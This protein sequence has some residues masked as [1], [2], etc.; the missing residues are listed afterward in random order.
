MVSCG[1][2]IWSEVIFIPRGSSVLSRLALLVFPSSDRAG[3]T[4]D[5]LR[6]SSSKSR[7]INIIVIV[8]LNCSGVVDRSGPDHFL[9]FGREV[10]GLSLQE[11]RS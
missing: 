3:W 5:T 2:T 4:S 1:D 11:V 9:E 6:V 7:F 10:K 8:V